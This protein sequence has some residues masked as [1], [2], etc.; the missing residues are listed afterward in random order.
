MNNEEQDLELLTRTY[1][2]QAMELTT[3]I[4]QSMN[5]IAARNFLID[6][7]MVDYFVSKPD[8]EATFL[9]FKDDVLSNAERLL[10]ANNRDVFESVTQILDQFESGVMMNKD[11]SNIGDTEM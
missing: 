4:Q 6:C 10:A 3:L 1:A 8:S 11:I 2:R 5:E 9:N 7:F